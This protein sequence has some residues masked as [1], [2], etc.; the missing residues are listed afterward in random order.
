MTRRNITDSIKA[1]ALD[2]EDIIASE[3]EFHGMLAVFWAVSFFSHYW[4]EL[5]RHEDM[6]RYNRKNRNALISQ[7]IQK[8]AAHF[9]M[10]TEHGET[11]IEKLQEFIDS[12]S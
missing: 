10:F 5:D 6:R 4:D 2:F 1:W 9:S 3:K 7:Y 11:S 8:I 12:I